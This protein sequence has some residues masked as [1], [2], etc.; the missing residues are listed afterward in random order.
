M[1]PICLQLRN[2]LSVSILANM[3]DDILSL[4]M[5]GKKLMEYDVALHSYGSC[6]MVVSSKGRFSV[7]GEI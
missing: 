4:G 2:V 5:L 6:Y 1:R 7:V 3:H